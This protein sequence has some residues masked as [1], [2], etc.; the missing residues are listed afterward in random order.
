LKVV[1]INVPATYPPDE[2]NGVMISGVPGASKLLRNYTYPESMQKKLDM[3]GYNID[4]SSI[5]GE[6]L[7]KFNDVIEKRLSVA[8]ELDRAVDWDLFIVVFTTPDRVQ[9]IFWNN[10]SIIEG[11]YKK[12]DSVVSE[13]IKKTSFNKNTIIFSDHGF[14]PVSNFIHFNNWFRDS[15]LLRLRK[16]LENQQVK[17][18]FRERVTKM[19]NKKIRQ[20]FFLS[21][22]DKTISEIKSKMTQDSSG[23]PDIDWCNT[24]AWLA[25]QGGNFGYI[26]INLKG[27]DPLGLVENGEQYH[28]LR[29]QIVN[30]LHMMKDPKTGSPLVKKVYIP[31][32]IFL[33]QYKENCCDILVEVSDGYVCNRSFGDKLVTEIQNNPSASHQDLGIILATGPDIK[34]NCEIFD[35]NIIQIAPT[36]LKLMGRLAKSNMDGEV[37]SK[38]FKTESKIPLRIKS[39]TD[40]SN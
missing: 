23:I 10:R 25:Q 34:E 36:I 31:E 18:T 27:R 22:Q 12:L 14:G 35:T 20:D 39:N 4:F 11:I 15:G 32:D 8:L 29:N 37:I 3:K 38:L 19:V 5:K 2:V 7:Q 28:S 24:E 17:K 30:E 40:L 9:H 1:V 13:L 26:S 6:D 16:S 33:G 21:I